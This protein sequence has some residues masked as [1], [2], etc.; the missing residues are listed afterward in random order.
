V[1]PSVEVTADGQQSRQDAGAR[2][3]QH[4]C[5]REASEIELR[6]VSPGSVPDMFRPQQ[7]DAA[8][9]AFQ[10]I[11]WD[12]RGR[13]RRR[14]TWLPAQPAE[15]PSGGAA[16]VLWYGDLSAVRWGPT[17]DQ[18]GHTAAAVPAVA[19]AAAAQGSNDGAGNGQKELVGPNSCSGGVQGGVLQLL[20]RGGGAAAASSGGAAQLLHRGGGGAAALSRCGAAQSSV[21]AGL[22]DE[23]TPGHGSAARLLGYSESGSIGMAAGAGERVAFNSGAGTCEN[24]KAC[25]ASGAASECHEDGGL[26]GA[27]FI[28]DA[29]GATDV[30]R[31]AGSRVLGSGS[32]QGTTRRGNRS[33]PGS[34][35]GDSADISRRGRGGAEAATGSGRS[36]AKA[37]SG[38]GRG[39]A[40]AA[41]G[42]GRGGAEAVTERGKG[43]GEDASGSG[44]S[45]AAK[46][47]YTGFA[48]RG[49]RSAPASKRRCVR[50]AGGDTNGMHPPEAAEGV[51]SVRNFRPFASGAVSSASAFTSPLNPL[52]P[53]S[54]KPHSSPSAALSM[55]LR[56]HRAGNSAH[57]PC[58]SA[59]QAKNTAVPASS[60]NLGVGLPGGGM[61]STQS[62]KLPMHAAGAPQ[63]PPAGAGSSA[64]TGQ[65]ENGTCGRQAALQAAALLSGSQR[66]A[67]GCEPLSTGAFQS[68]WAAHSAAPTLGG[69]R[70]SWDAGMHGQLA[71]QATAALLHKG[72]FDSRLQQAEAPNA[73]PLLFGAPAPP[74]APLL[75][76][77]QPPTSASGQS[78][79]N[80]AEAL[81]LQSMLAH[82]AAS[83][84]QGL[85][86]QHLI[87]TPSRAAHA[88][89]NREELAQAHAALAA[90]LF[91]P[92]QSQLPAQHQAS[93]LVAT[94]ASALAQ[95]HRPPAP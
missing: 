62:F 6:E 13:A 87:S 78:K 60:A 9:H 86:N 90:G 1:K 95:S 35:V 47:L 28:S 30:G 91:P 58:A 36:S 85:G 21:A 12:K 50:A 61:Q 27:G 20:Q 33:R 68:L 42:R 56:V 5:C 49:P 84:V 93:M 82:S 11:V 69:L 14:V 64:A 8:M 4:V 52:R 63:H 77:E 48:N 79:A 75:R 59:F 37:L 54:D 41:S 65:L 80:V 25:K 53:E 71:P 88:I 92:P 44:D 51:G 10:D 94:S 45:E 46:A 2:R 26:K 15:Q 81:D 17:R 19:T 7:I 29:T 31:K 32:T 34:G 83:A 57:V 38:R 55:P 67:P 24:G 74:P 73:N 72:G 18:D 23:A 89:P 43:W 70:P 39:G 22:H 76:I 40:E 3:C 66:S 16:S